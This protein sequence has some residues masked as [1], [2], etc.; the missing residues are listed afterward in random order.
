MVG[1]FK[2]FVQRHV[3]AWL[4]FLQSG[5]GTPMGK[6]FTFHTGIPSLVEQMGWLVITQRRDYGGDR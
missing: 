3:Q 6:G 4:L 2:F 1:I 5:G